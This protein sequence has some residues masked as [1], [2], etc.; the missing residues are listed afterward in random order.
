MRAAILRQPRQLAV[1]SVDDPR[2]GPREVVIAVERCGVCATDLH[3]FEGDFVSPYPLVPGHELSGVVAAVGSEV[4][5]LAVGDHVAADPT[6]TCGECSY[7]RTARPNHCERWG[8]IG[9]TTAGGFA[10]R[11]AVPAQ[12]VVPIGDLSFAEAA[13]I[14]PVACCVH[15]LRRLALRP[16]EDVCVFGAGAIGLQL[17]QLLRV[18]G[19]ARVVLVD[20]RAERLAVAERLR[21]ADR[22]LA[23]DDGGAR[24][25]R[26]IAPRGFSAVV[27][28]TGVAG[29]VEGM[30]QFL[31]PAGRALVFGVCG[32]DEVVRFSPFLLYKNDWQI[33]GSFAICY[34]YPPA[35]ALLRQRVIDVAPLVSHTLP[36]AELGSAL[37]MLRRGEGL[38]LQIAPKGA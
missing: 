25:L 8:A 26:A 22:V 24:A 6:L 15:G 31:A 5:D 12:N 32:K 28:A 18:G 21:F 14:E 13:F 7:C 27:D 36:L 34:S 1:G 30:F 35:A 23:G 10:E 16:G 3:I 33:L 11:V 2:P 37:E 29:V 4:G 20:R 17:A 9:V 38:K 19:A